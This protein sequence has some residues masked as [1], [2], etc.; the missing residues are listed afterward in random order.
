M[1]FKLGQWD[2][3]IKLTPDSNIVQ[4]DNMKMSYDFYAQ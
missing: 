4:E 3:V 2:R 1:R